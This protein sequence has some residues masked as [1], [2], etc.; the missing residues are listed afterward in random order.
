[1]V[2]GESYFFEAENERLHLSRGVRH[3]VG[4]NKI[5]QRNKYRKILLN[6]L[7]LQ[8]DDVQKYPRLC[9]IWDKNIYF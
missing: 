2:R 8:P 5:L 6:F 3:K 7:D 1:M 9:C 4:I